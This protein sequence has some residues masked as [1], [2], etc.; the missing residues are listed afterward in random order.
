MEINTFNDFNPT[1]NPKKQQTLQFQFN[2][3]L[4]KKIENGTLPPG[5]KLP[6]SRLIARDLGIS[7]N[8]VTHVFDQLKAEGYLTS[9]K[10]SGIFVNPTLPMVTERLSKG[11]W[12][13]K[14]QLPGLSTYGKKLKAASLESPHLMI[15]KKNLPFTP[16][17]PDHRAFPEKIW[18][19][20][21]RRHTDRALLK[22]YDN[23][24]GYLP[25]REAL[26]DYLRLSRGVICNED[27]I[28]ITQGAQQAITLC[29]LLLLDQ[30]DVVLMENPGYT[31]ARHAFLTKQA[32]LQPLE[33]SKNGIDV[34]SLPDRTKAKLMYTTPTHQYPLGGILSASQRLKLLDWAAAHNV[35]IIEDDYDSE[36]HFHGKP[37]ASIQGMAKRT[38]V[39]YIGSFSKTLY[40]AL[41]LG[42]MVVP[43]ELIETFTEAKTHLSGESPLLPQ[44]IVADFISEGHFIRHLRK[45]RLLYQEKWDHMQIL[46]KQNLSSLATPI[47]ESAG[48]HLALRIDTKS[49]IRLEN[50]FAKL[51]FG[52]T[53]L[54]SYYFE[55][56][57]EKGLVLGFACTHH[58]ERESGIIALRKLILNKNF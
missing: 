41:R 35:W 51:G 8:T 36:F 45:M 23:H 19:R 16:G 7:R 27:Q 32:E 20:I 22:G 6:P 12:A 1:L 58:Q 44:A 52:S 14:A 46:V 38:P 29:A 3:Y 53:A 37:I 15:N 11:A 31:N 10:G 47:A 2:R 28:I 56:P 4:L 39:I 21:Q 48:M 34:E 55:P 5:T 50:A 26:T 9:K 13:A 33:I 43:K 57:V 24:Q 54:S 18:T 17:V 25:L 49:D 42:Y 40:P 30:K